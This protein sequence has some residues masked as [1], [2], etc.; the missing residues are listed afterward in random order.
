[1]A[2]WQPSTEF[3]IRIKR[4]YRQGL[5]SFGR[6]RPPPW[7]SFGEHFAEI[8]NALM[9]EDDRVERILGDPGQSYLYYG[10]DGLYRDE[11]NASPPGAQEAGGTGDL[12]I[13][14]TALNPY[15][16]TSNLTDREQILP[17]IDRSLGIRVDFPN[18]FPSEN[19]VLTS[20]GRAGYRAVQAVYQAWRL[21]QITAIYGSRVLEIGAGTGR[22][23]YYAHK[24]GLSDYTIVDLPSTLVASANFL[25]ATIGENAIWLIGDPIE[26][27][28]DRIRLLTP[29]AFHA[30][31][32]KFDVI[33]NVDS[34]TEMPREDAERYLLTIVRKSKSFLSINHEQN[35]FSVREL[36]SIVCPT[37]S[38]ARNSFPMR[39]GYFEEFFLI[40]NNSKTTSE[41]ILRWRWW[42]LRAWTRC[43][44]TLRSL[45]RKSRLLT[46]LTSSAVRQ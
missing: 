30:G 33:I 4:A 11:V 40:P 14:A 31:N 23:A 43:R 37:I 1:M 27:Q 34:M 6:A 2:I 39:G 8:H 20:R 16:R 7:F 15:H 21:R 38:P 9:A 5:K 25:A 17:L 32:D 41:G 22:T 3:V 13:L 18:P 44:Q 26:Q 42:R 46:A 45:R 24:L 36:P 35:V 12:D 29:P 19:G 10:M 28:S